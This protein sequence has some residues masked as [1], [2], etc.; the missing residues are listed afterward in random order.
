MLNDTERNEAYFRALRR[1][2]HGTSGLHVLDIGAG[3]GLLSSKPVYV[4]LVDVR[5]YIM[6][7]HLGW[8]M[9]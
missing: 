2:L 4:F 3:T 7:A 8:A 5:T 6:Y 9:L 1:A